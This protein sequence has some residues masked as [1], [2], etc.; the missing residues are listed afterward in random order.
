MSLP[1][2]LGPELMWVTRVVIYGRGNPVHLAVQFFHRIT[3]IER[4]QPSSRHH[5]RATIFLL[6]ITMMV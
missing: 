1:L 5:L 4:A 2:G 3:Q 6:A